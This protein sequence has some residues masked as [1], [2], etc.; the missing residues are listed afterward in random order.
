M[1]LYQNQT[2]NGNYIPNFAWFNEIQKRVQATLHPSVPY[3]RD[4]YVEYNCVQHTI[5]QRGFYYA[6]SPS[7][8]ENKKENLHIFFFQYT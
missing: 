1:V 5:F 2:A 4:I 7:K 6:Q 3:D 8:L